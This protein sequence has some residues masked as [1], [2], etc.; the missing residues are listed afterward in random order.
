[1]MEDRSIPDELRETAWVMLEDLKAN[2][3]V[4]A[5]IPNPDDGKRLIRAAVEHNPEWYRSLCSSF[6][7]GRTRPRRKFDTL[8]KRAHTLRALSEI[9]EGRASSEYALRVFPYV[10]REHAAILQ[11]D[12]RSLRAL[13][14]LGYPSIDWVA[15]GVPEERD[16]RFVPILF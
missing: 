7:S 8:I 10:I 4:V 1:M 14:R 15:L 12:E 5:L 9:A 11:T 2:R 3:L 6:A 13:L 16:E